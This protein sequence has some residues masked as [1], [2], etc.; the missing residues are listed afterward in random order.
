LPSPRDDCLFCSIAREGAYVNK[1]KGFVAI[2]DINPKAKVHIL[3][4]PERHVDTFRDVSDF[5]A[6]ETKRMLD[7]VAETA[8]EAGL[9][10]Y[11]V[12]V[13]VGRSAGQTV[14]HLHWH[15]LGDDESAEDVPSALAT[16][17]ADQ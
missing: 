4:I 7:F 3:I 1:T 16:A 10:D 13:N 11:R 2:N 15:V 12:L 17:E 9:N 5:S 14:F 8:R 6:K